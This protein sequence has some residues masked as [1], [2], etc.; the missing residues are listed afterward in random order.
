MENSGEKLNNKYD[1]LEKKGSGATSKVYLVKDPETEKIYAAKVMK[2][3]TDYY[4]KEVEILKSL[5]SANNPFIVNL[6]EN[7]T[8]NVVLK[9]KVLE[10]K[11]YIVLE[12]APKGELFYYLYCYKQGLQ[13]KYSKVIFVKILRGVLSCHKAGVCHRDLKMQNILLDENYNPKICDFGFATFNT[14]KL[15]EFLGTINYA[16]P[17]ILSGTPYDGFKADI[18]SLGVILINLVT[19]KIGFGKA[20]RSDPF[21]R[22]IMGK[23]YGQ[24]WKLVSGEIKG[25]SDELKKLYNRMVSYRPN[26]RPTIEEIL[27]DD[28]I[29]EI[30]ELNEKQLKD[31]EK[32]ILEE[33]SKRE[34]I[35]N[36]HLSMKAEGE[37]SSSLD[38]NRGGG[39]DEKAYFDLSLKPNQGKTGINMRNYIKINGNLNPA[40]FMNNLANKVSQKFKDNCSINE[41][42]NALKFNITFENELE[43]EVELPKELEEEFAKLGIEEEADINENLLKKDCVIQ[44]KLYESLNGGHILKFSKKGGELDDYY[45]NL[46]TLTSLVKEVL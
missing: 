27:N 23:H 7:G 28:W 18:F 3:P 39:D 25:I 24:Y 17:E 9:D 19:C 35:V 5:K 31:L 21:Y 37:E 6:I 44:C 32:E 45:K 42:K 12:N 43:D 20:T 15:N 38:F 34:P 10:N 41:S 29:K 40:A 46:E 30:R 14:G 16:A 33:F 26:E 36:E 1:I 13:E 4:D 2:Q 11:Q 8:G 22:Y